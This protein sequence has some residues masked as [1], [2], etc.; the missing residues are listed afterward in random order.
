MVIN[1]FITLFILSHIRQAILQL[2]ECH[3]AHRTKG[4]ILRNSF[5]DFIC[6]HS[7]ELKL[8][9]AKRFEV[10]WFGSRYLLPSKSWGYCCRTHWRKCDDVSK[11]LINKL[12]SMSAVC[13]KKSHWIECVWFS[14]LLLAKMKV[15]WIN[16][17]KYFVV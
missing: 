8:W 14:V 4:E 17:I 1:I 15:P 10:W 16:M 13:C 2:S 9:K 7:L 5:F 6:F 11:S 3:V 12:Y